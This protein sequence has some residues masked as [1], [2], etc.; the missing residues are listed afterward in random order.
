MPTADDVKKIIDTDLADATIEAYLTSASELVSASISVT[1]ITNSLREEIIRWLTAHLIA[2]TQE[3]QLSKAGA[4]PT[5]V[6][7]QGKTGLG[8]DSTQYGQ[9]VQ[10]L[11][12]TRTLSR[13]GKGKVELFAIRSFE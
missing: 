11:D 9:Q 6:T 1:A 10:I 2:S 7:F 5:S 3:Q 12:T 13:L 8:L 4:G